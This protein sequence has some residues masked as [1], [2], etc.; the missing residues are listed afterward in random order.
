MSRL[1][2]LPILPVQALGSAAA[3]PWVW[4][5]RDAVADAQLHLVRRSLEHHV[6]GL[7]RGTVADGVCEQVFHRPLYQA[8]VAVYR[9]QGVGHLERH[10]YPGLLQGHPQEFTI[11]GIA[12]F[13]TADSPLGASLALFERDTAQE[14]LASGKYARS[15]SS[16]CS[17][18]IRTFRRR[19]I[20]C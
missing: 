17:S 10:L 7:P 15:T 1:Q 6:H 8:Q 16:A 5:I 20:A 11:V 4:L 2:D 9:W 13:V 12:R 19:S 18:A 3:P 14:I